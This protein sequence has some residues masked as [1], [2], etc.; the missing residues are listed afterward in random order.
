MRI[1]ELAGI[2]GL[3][4]HAIRY[5]EAE[6]L[7]DERHVQRGANGYRCY[8]PAAKDR[9]ELLKQARGSGMSM[10]E[11]KMLARAYDAG[12]LTRA[13]QIRFLQ[14]KVDGLSRQI[15]AD[16]ATRAM[17]VSKLSALRDRS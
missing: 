15:R 12:T 4:V 7:L 13:E 14:A 6:G 5:Y 11:V 2:T 3:S 8:R 17:L 1:G 16:R 10:A 9:L